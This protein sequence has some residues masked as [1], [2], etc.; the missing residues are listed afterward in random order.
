M[1]A[2]PEPA[3]PA[4]ERVAATARLF[5]IINPGS[6]A[7]DAKAKRDLLGEIFEAAG[8]SHQFVP[9]EGPAMLEGAVDKAAADAAGCG[10]VLVAVGGDGTIN[11]VAAA[12]LRQGCVLG[13]LPQGTFNLFAR[14]HGISQ[15]LETAAA[16]LIRGCPEPVQVAQVNGRVFLVNASL[17]LYPQ[18][19]QD[20][21]GFQDRFGR[22]RWVAIVSGLL[23]LFKWRRQLKL[24][25][26]LAGER[27]VLTTPT[28][29]VGNNRLQLQR[30]GIAEDTAARVGEGRLAAVAARPIGTMALMTLL[31]R[32][33][34]GTLGEA[35]QVHSFAF[36]SLKVQVRGM[37]RLK[38]AVDG[39][40]GVV[41]PP[42]LFA[43]STKP[44]M[45]VVPRPQDRVAVE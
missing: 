35:E 44:L 39:E 3:T 34:L 21:E 26:E 5:V 7:Q 17:G 31:L 8:R 29:F 30:I 15:D 10:G 16:A 28:L 25:I 9:I 20:R 2:V 32:G 14:S 1:L 33:A 45:L 4:P 43:V 41:T 13:V 24:E 18:L 36:Q 11:T 42:L 22:R 19:L 38:V 6:G 23:T 12:A 40:V 37:R 27:T